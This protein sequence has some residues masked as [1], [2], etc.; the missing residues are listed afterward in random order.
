MIQK[1]NMQFIYLASVAVVIFAIYSLGIDASF[2]YDDYRPIGALV[3]VTDVTSAITY[4]FSETSGPLGR[5]ISMLSFL[6]HVND[7]PNNSQAFFLGNIIIHL[8]CGGLIYIIA[9]LTIKLSAVSPPK[10][11]QYPFK[12]ALACAVFWLVLPINAATVFIAIQRMAQ[13]TTMFMLLGIALYLWGLVKQSRAYEQESSNQLYISIVWQVAGVLL[14]SLLAIFSKENGALLPIFILVMEIT[15]LKH[16]RGIHQ[17]RKHRI[18]LGIVALILISITLIISVIKTGNYPLGREFTT[19]ERLMTQP[20]VLLDYLLLSFIPSIDAINPFHDNYSEATSF[21]NFY[22]AIAT[23]IL[24]SLFTAAIHYRGK[25]PL[26]SF[27]VLW[28]LTAHLIESTII[29][30]ELF[31]LHRNYIALVGPCIAIVFAISKYEHKRAIYCAFIAYIILLACALAMTANTWGNKELAAERWFIEQGSSERASEHLSVMLFNQQKYAESFNV[32]NYQAQ[33]CTNCLNAKL[34]SAIS[35]CFLN[36]KLNIN[37]IL[38]DVKTRLPEV[39]KVKGLSG[40]L[41]TLA[42]LKND[43]V[44]PSINT[45]LL[46]EINKMLFQ[47]KPLLIRNDLVLLQNM[48]NISVSNNDY[49]NAELYIKKAWQLTTDP[50]IAYEMLEVF[51]KLA[52]QEEAEYLITSVCNS[53]DLFKYP[54]MSQLEYCTRFKAKYKESN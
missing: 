10:V 28:F 19:V 11:E 5:P 13:L 12:I 50:A 42:K 4:V 46:Y 31:F 15:I 54:K 25:V 39:V 32:A 44:C 38:L 34:Q 41:A 29:P 6:P 2:Y 20:Q 27:A 21:F 43:G 22:T 24:I 26:F 23:F 3:N 37:N 35:A 18:L 51:K 16:C 36:D 1:R 8:V 45:S 40:K 47:N 52:K 9:Y 17:F 30:L 14:G 48:Y 49:V 7:W 33:K 53:S